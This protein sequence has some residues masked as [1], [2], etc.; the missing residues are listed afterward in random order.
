MITVTLFSGEKKNKINKK[1]ILTNKSKILDRYSQVQI[2]K[3][4]FTT[5]SWRVLSFTFSAHQFLISKNVVKVI[6]M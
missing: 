2:F 6:K 5:P 4:Q 1:I 3:D